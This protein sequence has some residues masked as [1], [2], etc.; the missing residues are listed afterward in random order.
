MR[1]KQL[2]AAS[3][4]AD[5]GADAAYALRQLRRAP[6]FAAAAVLTLGLGIGGTTAIFSAFDAVVLRPL[7]FP[8][9]DRL[10]DV[11]TAWQGGPGAV[12]AGNFALIARHSRAFQALATRNGAT[13]NLTGDGEPERVAGARVSHEYFSVLGLSPALGRVFGP[14]EEEPGNEHVVVLSQRLHQRRFGADPAVVGR[15]I[16]LGGVPHE[17][18]GVMTAGFEIPGDD[19]ELWK[20]IAFTAEQRGSFD[21]HY[22]GVLGRLRP[23]VTPEQLADDLGRVAA[24]LV[25]AQPRDNEDRRLVA[26]PLVERVAGD[27]RARLAILLAA[28]ALVLLIACANVANLL[29]ARLALRERE[30]AV[31]AAL[32][33]GRGR[34]ARQL[35]AEA[36][37]LCSLGGLL[38]LLLAT[39][40][41]RLLVAHAPPGVPRLDQA[42]LDP[43]ALALA[44]AVVLAATLAAGLAPAAQAG[45]AEPGGRLGRRGSVGGVRDRL[46]Q[47]LIA[48]EVGLA[49]MLL[50][51]AGLL[52]RSGANLDRVPPGFDASDLLSA[53]LALPAAAYPGDELPARAFAGIVE[54]LRQSPGVAGAAASSRP[55]LI[56]NITYGLL[57][58]G[59]APEPRNRIN[60]RLQLVTPGYLELLRIPLRRGR[61][62]D[63]S[64][65]RGAPRAMIVNETL[66]RQAFPG[67]DA[68]GR[69]IDCC[70]SDGGRPIWKEIVGVVGDTRARGPAEAGFAE[71]YLPIDQAP[72]RAFDAASRS[73]TLVVRPAGGEPERLAGALRQAVR[74]VDPSLPLYDVATMASRLRGS[75]RVLRFNAAL[76]A[77]LG[78]VGLALAAV[79]LY[80]VIA[81][82]VGQRTRE[83]GVRVAL[84]ARP[85]QV[86]G[87]LVGQGLRALAAGLLLGALG[88][89]A[90]ARLLEGAL[91]GVSARDPATLGVGAGL[92]LAVGL[93]AAALPARRAARLDPMRA[94]GYDHGS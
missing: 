71:F 80:G 22:L 45:R 91:F 7:P 25:R 40:S 44:A 81:Y 31:R 77:L 86:V 43:R 70:E 55:P 49:L 3:L 58:E 59:R 76:L 9:P 68:I 62:F 94:L 82:L 24:E 64:D 75:T 17:V 8:E 16:E 72:M 2:N 90:Q 83:I 48:G 79:G 53:R 26:V 52:V 29:L 65:R 11:A 39:L 35:L 14:A 89:L 42:A 33:A 23:G 74:E 30:L 66:A 85:A 50:T 28:M 60:S 36:F 41:L 61:Y 19:A 27:N 87:L 21:A 5:T 13:Y 38:G 47:A 78:G 69:R 73:L 63:E 1:F 56:G 10:I 92:L 12:S 4:A 37:V 34:L 88:C 6:G 32:G 93:A 18:L 20:P 46:R 51:G 84:G 54:R 67:R 57:P 15:R